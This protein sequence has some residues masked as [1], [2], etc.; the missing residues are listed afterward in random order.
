MP[1][2]DLIGPSWEEEENGSV[3]LAQADVS[4]PLAWRI[5]RSYHTKAM[6]KALS[7]LPREPLYRRVKMENR[8]WP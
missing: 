6:T 8:A 3:I 1:A 4:R 5:R 2:L 7:P